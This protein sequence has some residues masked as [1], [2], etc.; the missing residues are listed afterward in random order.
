MNCLEDKNAATI[1]LSG[2]MKPN[3]LPIKKNSISWK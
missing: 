3:C 1:W 2:R